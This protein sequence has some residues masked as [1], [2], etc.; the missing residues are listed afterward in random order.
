MVDS[1]HDLMDIKKAI[2]VV[3]S[4]IKTK[5]KVFL[6][7]YGVPSCYGKLIEDREKTL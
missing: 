2:D 1:K 4:S 3:E 7:S 6:T 5:W